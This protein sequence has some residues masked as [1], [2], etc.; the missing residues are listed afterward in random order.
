MKKAL[1]LAAALLFAV[2]TNLQPCRAV[3]VDGV[4]SEKLYGAREIRLGEAAAEAAAEEIVRGEPA[5]PRVRTAPALSFRAPDGTAGELCDLI[6]SHTE[7]VTRLYSV[8]AGELCFGTVEDAEKLEEKLRASLYSRM[9]PTSGRARYSE[10]IELIPVYGLSGSDT[11][12]R[13]MAQLVA[14]AVPAVFTDSDG[15]IVQG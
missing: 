10:P 7:G 5:L 13:D 14:G 6:L 2:C 3:W 1:L 8:R 11:P 9:P 15:H 12:Y 4:R